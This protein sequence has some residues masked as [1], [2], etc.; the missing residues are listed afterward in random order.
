M[1]TERDRAKLINSILRNYPLPSIFLYCRNKD[2]NIVYDVIDGKQRIESILMFMG[3]KRGNRYWA[4]AQL[5]EDGPEEWIDWNTLRKKKLQHRIT[6][7]KLQ[8]IETSGDAGE[9]IELFVRINST[10]KALTGAEKRH[11]KYFR[12]DFLKK[13]GQ[14]ATKYTKYFKENG[15]LSSG[16]VS[17]MKHVEL[18]CELMVSA[19]AEGVINKKAALDKIME[20]ESMKGRQLARVTQQ[21]VTSLNRLKKV[22]P[23]VRQT[24][25]CKLSDFYSLAVLLQRFEREGLILTDKVRNQVAWDLLVNFSNG[26]DDVRLKR[27]QLEN[28]QP[29][30]AL[31]R[32]YLLTVMEATDEISNR[33][34]RERVLYGLLASIFQ[35]KDS[36]RIF[37][38]EQRRILWNTTGVPRCGICNKL[39]SWHDFTIDHKT[40]HSIGGPT[41]LD[42]AELMCR[43]DNSGKGNKLSIPRSVK[44]RRALANHR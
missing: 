24:R 2:G 40:A 3:V 32:E 37:S 7:Y 29:G 13:A 25:F 16:Q 17:R 30:Q 18:V 28:L 33:R 36:A 21:V 31:Y 9:I 6:G 20:S 38:Q 4:K 43:K 35:K 26:V 19:H 5:S 10:G 41:R 15:V 42:N 34:Q 11:A 8:A 14:L 23:M 22:F 44:S 1:W 12:S 27:K 39:L